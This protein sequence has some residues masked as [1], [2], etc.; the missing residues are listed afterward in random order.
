MVDKA[1]DSS[2]IRVITT[3]LLMWN[4]SPSRNNRSQAKVNGT[5]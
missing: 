2:V 3:A 1:F 5:Q 4:V